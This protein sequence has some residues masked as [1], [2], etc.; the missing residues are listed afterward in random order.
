MNATRTM[1]SLTMYDNVH[2]EPTTSQRM[3]QT[4][5]QNRTDLIHANYKSKATVN[6]SCFLNNLND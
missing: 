3:F 1:N 4:Y 5:P 2:Y 6:T